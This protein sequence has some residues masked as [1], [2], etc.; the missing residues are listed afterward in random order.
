M[1]PRTIGIACKCGKRL[2]FPKSGVGKPARCP[3]CKCTLRVV[4]HGSDEDAGM[5]RGALI[6]LSGPHAVG[7][8]IFLAGTSPV[9]VG[10]L[11]DADLT[12]IGSQVS[13][14]HCRLVATDSGWRIEDRK[15]TNGLF[16]N[17]KRIAAHELRH[18]DRIRIGDYELGYASTNIAKRG[19]SSGQQAVPAATPSHAASPEPD[20]DEE[21]DDGTYGVGGNLSDLYALAEGGE[22]IATPAAPADRGEAQTRG[23]GTVC[24]SCDRQMADSAKIC[25]ACGIDVRTGRSIITAEE[26]DLDEIYI[27]AEG[28]ISWVSWLVWAGAYPIA[29]EAFG[30]RRPYV[31]RAIAII[32]VLVSVWFL[33]YEWSG[34]PRMRTMKNL[35]L[36]AGD[37]E[38]YPEELVPLYAYTSFGDSEA[39]FAE[40]YE[41]QMK[42]P[43]LPEREVASAAHKALRPDQQAF[44]QYR[45]SQLITHAFLHGGIMHLAGNLL[46][47]LVFGSR[48]NALVGNTLTVFLYP[49]LAVAAA[50]AH[51]ASMAGAS[52]TPMLG[53][54]GAIMGLAG[55]Y[56][57]FFPLHKVHMAAWTRWGLTA[58]FHLSLKMWSLRGFWVVLFYIA[59]D[60]VFTV[61]GIE[62]QTAHWAH[63]GGFGMGVGVGVVLLCTRLVNSR[64]GD[65][66]SAI[67]GRHAWAL[68][69][70]PRQSLGIL[71]TL[72]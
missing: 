39:F 47:L 25:I 66:I 14:T 12:L 15:S 4:V 29:S 36:W 60:V 1:N 63:L 61:Y 9:E 65:I 5:A 31:T 50:L 26:P 33:A 54:S 71:Q 21:L 55:M 19:A 16:V 59:F 27:R 68:V 3:S 22:V 70:R 38:W 62:D 67:L 35:M 58:G 7:E 45:S 28:A 46:F 57:A 41:I 23:D 64:G 17:G 43:E 11:T 13:R 53:A 48:V 2:G 8:Q 69:G 24:P 10:K 40:Y 49:L 20:D 34:S 18:G 72:P 56:F 44:G 32:T 52:P 30:L 51:M 42:N 6:V 37:A